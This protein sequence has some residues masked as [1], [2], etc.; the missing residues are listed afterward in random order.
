M[1]QSRSAG[2]YPFSINNLI[3]FHSPGTPLGGCGGYLPPTEKMNK[4]LYSR[5]VTAKIT[6]CPQ[7]DRQQALVLPRGTRQRIH[8]DDK[9]F[10]EG[11]SFFVL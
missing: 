4:E 1:W 8:S 11:F 5:N 6:H 3:D 10:A 9:L 7:Y 2:M